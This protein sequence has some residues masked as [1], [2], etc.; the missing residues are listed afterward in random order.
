M[1][2][3]DKPFFMKHT[4]KH[5]VSEYEKMVDQFEDFFFDL[6]NIKPIDLSSIYIIIPHGSKLRK[7]SVLWGFSIANKCKSKV[8]IA[9]RRTEKIVREIENL[10]RGLGVEFEFLEGDI[11]KIME[12]IKKEGSLVVLPR[13]VIEGMKEEKA[14]SPILVI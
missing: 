3:K 14:K 11:D 4:I 1:E 8:Y 7:K 13:D 9:T 5:G 10:S 6:E 2:E 12:E